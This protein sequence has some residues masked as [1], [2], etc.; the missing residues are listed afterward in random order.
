MITIH[1]NRARGTGRSKMNFGG[2]R[3]PGMSSKSTSLRAM[4]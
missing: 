1:F 4:A 2:F 3:L